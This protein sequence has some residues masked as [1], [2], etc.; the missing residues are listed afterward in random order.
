MIR[1]DIKELSSRR[2]RCLRYIINLVVK[3]FLFGNDEESFETE[4]MTKKEIQYL[5]AVRKEWLNSRLYRKFH[6]TVQF[7]RDT[8]QRR[9]EWEAITGSGI[10]EEFEGKYS[11]IKN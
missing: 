6:N 1:P 11:S 2:V 7:I 8:S 5:L 4:E 3:A 9:D 10:L